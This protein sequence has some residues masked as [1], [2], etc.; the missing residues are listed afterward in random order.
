M[1]RYILL[2]LVLTSPV[3]I[4]SQQAFRFYQ[5]NMVRVLDVNGKDMK[6]PFGG[7]IKFPVFTSLDVN[8]DGKPDLIVL[9]RADD[10]ILTFINEGG[11]DTIKYTYRPEYEDLFPDT[12]NRY[13]LFLDYN[14][15]G[16][17][18]LFTFS[19][20]EGTGVEIFRNISF[21]NNILFERYYPDP[22]N[23]VN[24]ALI[25]SFYG[26]SSY[27]TRITVL[28]SD[29]PCFLDADKDG[30]IDF[31]TFD[32]L[33][34]VY[35]WY[36]KNF[37]QEVNGNADSM[38]IDM[39]D[40]YWGYFM[41][42][43]KTNLVY[44]GVTSYIPYKD[45]W[46]TLPG[47]KR[48]AGSTVF[49]ND[50]DGDGD[51]DLLVGDIGYPGIRLLINGKKQTNS[52]FDSIIAQ[53]T[54]YPT[55]KPVNIH[56]M[57]GTFNIDINN[58]GIKDYIFSPM[59][60]TL[61]DLRYVDGL[62]QV[63]YYKNTGTE[64]N[65]V[66]SF[67]KDNFLQED[68]IDLGGSTSP[69]FFDFDGDGDLDMFVATKGNN[70]VTKYLAD[71]I[72]LFENVGTANKPVFQK[73]NDDYLNL[74]A[75]GFKSLAI[76]FGDVDADGN[77][78]LIMGNSIGHLIFYKNN[79]VNGSAVFSYVTDYFDSIDVGDFSV[80]ATADL[81]NDLIPELII[82]AKRG[83]LSYW[84]NS[85]TPGNPK[86]KVVPDTF[87]HINIPGGDHYFSPIIEDMDTNGHPDL[88]LTYNDI[89]QYP[90]GLV[91]S[92]V[93]IYKDIDLNPGK[94]FKAYDTLFYNV[95][96]GN[97]VKKYIGRKLKPAVA[98]LDGDSLPDLVFGSDRGGLLFYGTNKTL[99]TKITVT[100]KTLLCQ[101]DSAILDAGPGYESYT[102]NTGAHTQQIVV[103]N[104]G[105]YE[106]TVTK[107]NFSYKAFM[108]IQKHPGTIQANYTYL[109]NDLSVSFTLLNDNIDSVRW[110]FGDGNYSNDKNPSHTYSHSGNY[111]VCVEIYDN[112][113]ASDTTCKTNYFAGVNEDLN[114]QISVYPNPAEKMV[115]I[116][117]NP[118]ITGQRFILKVTDI[119]GREVINREFLMKED[120]LLDI[121]TFIPGV[122]PLTITDLK[123]IICKKMVLVKVGQ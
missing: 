23:P 35:L 97:A 39:A 88:I 37:S 107:G 119:L 41:E 46:I 29:I 111:T 121:K 45:Y 18:D 12:L 53:D 100:G 78:D 55:S 123:G 93:V 42:G 90:V 68:M 105:S 61:I 2:I 6:N 106:C 44:L 40:S 51:L 114:C 9:D 92:K 122:Y 22:P 74:S 120:I 25:S 8:F 28:S 103:K 104:A 98:D 13:I 76:H 75:K 24:H 11:K 89:N 63:W 36:F 67:V 26:N 48:H 110:S 58:D 16:K 3:I 30:D 117:S 70:I 91:T 101:G 56:N 94:P 65:P 73:I 108:N 34:G 54:F 109:N 20:F 32:D 112:C 86:F 31:Y 116:K 62:N 15:D 7:G 96:T 52:S 59:D 43:D 113:G 60:E 17:P 50:M 69:A 57:P 66:L 79:P 47:L 87:G 1:K 14:N 82:G 115:F 71:R 27:Q 118:G 85:G 38:K 49:V 95:L 5:S 4:Y 84:K 19:S 77:K 72:V 81:D 64:N 21:G 33:G 102:W 10:R 83:M 80:P 99:S